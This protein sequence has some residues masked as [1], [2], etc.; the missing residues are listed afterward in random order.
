MAVKT[1]SDNCILVVLS[2][3]PLLR[4]EL[5][6]VNE[7]V[8]KKPETD[9]IVDF[10]SVEVLTSSSISSLLLLQKWVR[11]N[12]RRLILCSVALPTKGI[13]SVAGLSKGFEFADNKSAALKLL[14]GAGGPSK[15]IPGQTGQS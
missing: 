14:Q 9:V 12:E 4:D 8:S 15:L 11:A 13:F 10:S 5:E 7:T 1:L 2:K 6:A 3:E